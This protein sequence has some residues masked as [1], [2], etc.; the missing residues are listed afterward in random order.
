M[1][2]RASFNNGVTRDELKELISALC[3]VLWAAGGE[4]HDASGAAGV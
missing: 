2:L 1:H 4:C 3:A